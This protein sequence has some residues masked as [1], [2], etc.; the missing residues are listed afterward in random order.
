MAIMVLVAQQLVK[1]YRSRS[2]AVRALNGVDLAVA[3][4]EFLAVMGPSGSGKSTLLHLLGGLDQ[5]T[6]GAVVVRGQSLFDMDDNALTRF[7]RREIGFVF[8][9][10]NLLPTLSAE[11]NI[12]LPVAIG[13]E[14][15][16]EV[17]HRFR[18]LVRLLG[19][20]GRLGH[21]P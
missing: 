10:F 7:R 15:N 1:E 21:R 2:L 20:G 3:P 5:P 17:R 9:F 4:G 8:Q 6:S 19:L 12:L 18:Q 14:V 11:E 13:G 16:G